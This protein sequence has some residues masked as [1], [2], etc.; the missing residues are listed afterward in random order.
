[1]WGSKVPITGGGS[2]LP[3]QLHSGWGRGLGGG[4]REIRTELAVTDL[5]VRMACILQTLGE[6]GGWPAIVVKSPRNCVVGWWFE[7]I[8]RALFSLTQPSPGDTE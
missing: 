7:D 6:A 8:S 5:P 4:W 1:M 3:R 2:A